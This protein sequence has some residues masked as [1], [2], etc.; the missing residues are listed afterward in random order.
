MKKSVGAASD[1]ADKAERSGARIVS[2][3]AYIQDA[4][5][6]HCEP[7]MC[8]GLQNCMVLTHA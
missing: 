2:P 1:C 3:L 5:K 4:M 8:D 6:T 7:T